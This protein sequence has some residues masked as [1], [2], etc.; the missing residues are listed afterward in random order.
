MVDNRNSPL[1]S[2]IM[3]VYNG[4]R[5][6]REAINSI[7]CQ[8]LRDFEFIIIN[9]GSTDKTEEIIFS[10]K[11]PR[12]VY[13]KNEC[14]LKVIKSLN[15]GIDLAK[16]KYIARMDADDI[17]LPER[18]ETQM[19]YL[20]E[21][22][23]I[24]ACSPLLVKLSSDGKKIR[25]SW[26]LYATEKYSCLFYSLL[27]VPIIHA[28]SVIKT[29]VMKK[30]KYSDIQEAMHVEA[31]D[32]WIRMLH[33]GVEMRAIP[34]YLY[35]Y[36]DNENSISHRYIRLQV[37]NHSCYAVKHIKEMLD[38][39]TDENTVTVYFFINKSTEYENIKKAA[40]LLKELQIKFMIRYQNI[41]FDDQKQ[42]RFFI[43]VMLLKI[44]IKT[45]L[46]AKILVKMKSI[47]PFFIL[48]P[49]LF[50]VQRRK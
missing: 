40:S 12:I 21:H 17:S 16:G 9:D 11:D 23:E 25:K 28:G 29:D 42:I 26:L 34:R 30:Y 47:V 32:L 48:N 33:D 15:I 8:T 37:H 10:Y 14:N 18:F 50:N 5:F 41:S 31:Y 39:D 44:Y 36:R 20:N 7:L 35:E 19:Q 1:I 2:V 45:L 43:R 46:R 13:V 6:L 22:P 3:P 4:E 27:V 49:F 38:V 24:Q